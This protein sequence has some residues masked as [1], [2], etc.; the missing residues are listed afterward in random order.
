[1]AEKADGSSI[2]DECTPLFLFLFQ[3]LLTAKKEENKQDEE[4]VPVLRFN[5][6]TLIG[7]L[8]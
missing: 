3:S 1:M 8:Y 6:I 2:L 5:F 4:V 7:W